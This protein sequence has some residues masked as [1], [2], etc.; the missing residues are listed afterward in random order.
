MTT[1]PSKAIWKN[2]LSRT[3][4]VRRTVGESMQPKLKPHR[5]LLATCWYR[6]LKPGDLVVVHHEGMEKV[7][8]IELLEESKM[9][10]LGDNSPLSTDSRQFGWVGTE[11]VVGKVIWPRV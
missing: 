4:V 7:K 8:R 10:L 9:Y 6:E 11:L 5:L 3:L 2:K 1:M